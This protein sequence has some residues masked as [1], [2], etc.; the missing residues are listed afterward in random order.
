LSLVRCGKNLIIATMKTHLN[1]DGVNKMS[2]FKKLTSSI[3]NALEM[4]G[5]AKTLAH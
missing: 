1:T 4:A 3:F 2:T 5:R